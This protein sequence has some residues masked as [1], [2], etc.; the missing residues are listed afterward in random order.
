MGSGK[1]G[2]AMFA[3]TPHNV[4]ATADVTP[5]AAAAPPATGSSGEDRSELFSAAF[6]G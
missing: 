3:G 2:L 5:D 6:N 1:S 4:T